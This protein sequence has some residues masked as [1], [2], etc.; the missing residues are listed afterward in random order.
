MSTLAEVEAY[1]PT[2]DT[3]YPNW[4][5]LVEAE[6][7]GYVVTAV[8]CNDT[9]TLFWSYSEGP[10]PSKDEASKARSRLRRRYRNRHSFPGTRLLVINVRPLWKDEQEL[11]S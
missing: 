2:T 4:D 1:S 9:A 3:H 6:A 8:L 7:N 10:Y 11:R 5:A